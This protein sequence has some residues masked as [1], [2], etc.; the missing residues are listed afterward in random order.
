MQT[1][2]IVFLILAAGVFG[3]SAAL[4]RSLIAAGLFFW[5]LVF[6]VPLLAK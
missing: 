1:L 2:T 6:L 5:V 4:E 3:I